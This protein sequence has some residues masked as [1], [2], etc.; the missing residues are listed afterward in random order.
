MKPVFLSLLF[1]L[2][3]V[4]QS[5]HAQVRCHGTIDAKLAE[6]KVEKSSVKEIVMTRYGTTE[7]GTQGYEAWVRLDSCHG[8][9]VI[10]VTE[11]CSVT[12]VYTTGTCRIPGVPSY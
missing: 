2:M 3:S 11:A 9:L 5:V 7:G 4:A 6:L 10:D 8:H 1:V 12:T